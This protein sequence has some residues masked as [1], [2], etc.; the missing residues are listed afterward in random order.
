MKMKKVLA[1]VLA[2]VMLVSV[3]ASC[4]GSKN[5]LKDGQISVMTISLYGGEMTES[6]DKDGAVQKAVEEYTGVSPVWQFVS[7]EGYGDKLNMTLMDKDNMPMILTFSGDISTTI[8]QAAQNDAFWDLSQFINPTDYPNLAQCP[9]NVKDILTVQ[10]KWIAI[11]TMR[12]TGRYGLS[13]RGD[14]AAKLGIE[15]PKTIDDVYN[16]LYAFTY[17][18]PDGNGKQDTYGL[19]MNSGYSDYLK[20]IFS[21]F[22]ITPDWVEKDGTLVPAWETDEYKQACDWIRKLTEDGLV[23]PDWASVTA[24]GWGEQFQKGNVGA[25]VDTLDGGGRRAWRY[26]TNTANDV[27]SV[28]DTPSPDPEHP[29]NAWTEMVSNIN[30]Y[31]ACLAVYKGGYLITKAGAK[32]EEDVKNC[33]KFL[34]KMNDSKMRAL[35]ELGIEGVSYHME[36]GY[37]VKEE[38]VEAQNLPS[39]GLNQVIAY[40]PF[41]IDDVIEAKPDVPAEKCLEAE[42]EARQYALINPALAYQVQSETYVKE[43]SNIYSKVTNAMIRYCANQGT[44]DEFQA[45]VA[46]WESLGGAQIK[47]EVNAAYQANQG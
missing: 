32:T 42:V 4:G 22:G 8:I 43:S 37:A 12:E 18:D 46:E 11:P 39:Q 6:K 16:M 44:W 10:G 21:W 5:E 41:T 14:W 33:L 20:I 31:T 7:S 27:K 13:Y 23:R 24:D 26:F 19:E 38:G 3:L 45:A 17:N 28:V 9:D 47:E 25:F 35:A 15:K 30:G 40:L 2:T 29:D 1:L 34:D 36:D